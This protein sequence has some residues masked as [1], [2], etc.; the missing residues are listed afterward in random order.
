MA[1]KKILVI[2]EGCVDKFIYCATKRLAPD[3]PVPV[4]HVVH[5]E[6]NPGMAK[7][8]E[9]NI[10]ALHSACDIVT[11]ADWKRVTKTR[12]MHHGSNQA[13]FR[14]DVGDRI[15]RVDVRKIPLKTYDIVAIS[16][17][18]KGF[19]TNEDLRYICERHPVVFI[20]S[21]KPVGPFLSKVKFIK[22]NEKEYERSRPVSKYLARKIICTKSEKGA[23]FKGVTYPIEK[24]EVRDV[25]GAG[26][27]FFAALLVHYA[28]T[29]RIEEAIKFAN[30]CAKHVVQ[31]KGVSVIQAPTEAEMATL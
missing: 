24:V 30:L 29:G 4:L 8:L 31:Q 12:Y 17:Y 9:R 25:S 5:T 15:A 22:I 14:V 18:D 7:N 2:G 6:E 11:N 10:R 16:D 1:L 20:D 21:K 3:V 23:E 26:D 27:S 19:L 13:F 28:K